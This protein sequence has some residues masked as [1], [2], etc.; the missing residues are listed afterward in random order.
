MPP[1]IH[2]VT[3]IKPCQPKGDLPQM[4]GLMIKGDSQPWSMTTQSTFSAEQRVWLCSFN[5]HLD[6]VW[7]E[8][9]Q[10]LINS[11]ALDGRFT[12]L[13]DSAAGSVAGV[14]PNETGVR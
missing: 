7:G 8:G 1:Y 13:I 12:T 9:R 11:G 3:Q 14:K 4:V 2:L 5:I 6:Q 10:D